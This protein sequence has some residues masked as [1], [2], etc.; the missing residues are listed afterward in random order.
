MEGVDAGDGG[1]AGLVLAVGRSR[2]EQ[3]RERFPAGLPEGRDVVREDGGREHQDG[4]RCRDGRAEG[5][6]DGIERQS[7]R[8]E[9]DERDGD[10][11]R[12]RAGV[13]VGERGQHVPDPDEPEQ[14]EQDDDGTREAENRRC[15]VPVHVRPV[16]RR[17][18]EATDP[19]ARRPV[20]F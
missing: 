5:V 11:E 13:G 20:N 6:E 14:D 19:A 8:G 15:P 16:G 17:A 10:D 18:L 1:E 7:P 3:C 9:P 2:D 4:L 12:D